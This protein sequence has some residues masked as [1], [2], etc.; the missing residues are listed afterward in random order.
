VRDPNRIYAIQAEVTK[1]WTKYPDLRFFQML[2][3][4]E[5]R[6]GISYDCFMLEDDTTLEKLK[7]LNNES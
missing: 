7:E 6:M 1:F 2:T 5:H 3:I 4:L